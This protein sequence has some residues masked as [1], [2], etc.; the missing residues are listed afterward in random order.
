MRN[1]IA[2]AQA[3]D[4]MNVS[5]AFA[6]NLKAE[7]YLLDAYSSGEIS[8]ETYWMLT[9]S[10]S[11]LLLSDP[12]A[13]HYVSPL[14]GDI[15]SLDPIGA[16]Y[17]SQSATYDQALSIADKTGVLVNSQGYRVS[18]SMLQALDINHDNVLSL[19][20][21][22]G[23]RLLTDV[24]ENGHLD[25]AELNT[26]TSGIWSVDWSRL[27]RGNAVLA[28]YSTAAPTM[29][30]KALPTVINLSQPTV[31]NLSQPS[32]VTLAQPGQ[33]NVTQAVPFSNY[34]TLRDT[35]NR[36]WID[37]LSWIDWSPGQV[38]IN[39]GNRNI[40][41]GTDG[42]DAFDASI[43]SAYA[44][45]FPTPLTQFMGG[46]G[47]D[48]V[49]G[50]AGSDTVWGGTGNDT[51]LGYTGDD[52]LYGEEGSDTIQGQDGNDYLDGGTGDDQKHSR[53]VYFMGGELELSQVA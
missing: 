4:Q 44:S 9:T 37:A 2:I 39:N 8:S 53:G 7:Y 27:T 21:A 26:V 36:Y 34:R 41:I 38:K 30:S 22:T 11:D 46:G 20:E 5:N 50:S 33:V 48:L 28:E 40:M 6:D 45:W 19:S 13:N 25:A 16:F 49:G 18:V 15:L 52:K 23:L 3:R 43:Y 10:V 47:D 31:V 29:A 24:N 35:D 17:D 12:N 1:A 51:L 14:T 42:N 32:A